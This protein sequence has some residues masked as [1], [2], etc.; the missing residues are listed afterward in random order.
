MEEEADNVVRRPCAHSQTHAHTR[1]RAHTHTHTHT[2]T[3]THTQVFHEK[4]GRLAGGKD[5]L[6]AL[7]FEQEQEEGEESQVPRIFLVLNRSVC[8]SNLRQHLSCS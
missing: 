4:V 6:L 8:I 1:A 3:Q 5:V 7:G 2:Q